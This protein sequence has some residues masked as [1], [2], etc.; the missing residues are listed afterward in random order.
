MYILEREWNHE[1]KKIANWLLNIFFIKNMKLQK[2]DY[3][4]SSRWIRWCWNYNLVTNNKCF[5]VIFCTLRNSSISPMNISSKCLI[6]MVFVSMHRPRQ[7]ILFFSSH[8]SKICL[9]SISLNRRKNCYSSG[10]IFTKCHLKK[11]L[12]H[13]YIVFIQFMD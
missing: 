12:P 5:S 13:R 1:M 11:P 4:V 3:C 6:S 8:D 9:F 10:K 2:I 7:V